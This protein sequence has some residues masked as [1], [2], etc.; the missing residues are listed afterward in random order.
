MIEVDF[1]MDMPDWEAFLQDRPA[2]QAVPAGAFLAVLEQETEDTVEEAFEVLNDL[3]LTLDMTSMPK[4]VVQGTLAER[5]QL[6]ERLVKTGLKP[7]AFQQTDPLRL[8]LEELAMIPA[9]GDETR[10][11]KQAAAGDEDAAMRLTNLGLSRVVEL[12]QEFVGRGVLLLDL[13]QEGSLALWQTVQ[14]GAFDNYAAFRDTCIRNAMSKLVLLQARSSGIGQKMRAALQDYRSVDEQ[15]LAELGR[16]PTAK[17]IAEKLHMTVEETEIVKKMLDD[18]VLL[19]QTENGMKP[20]E[21]PEEEDQA[22]EDTAYFQ[23]R[24]RIQELLSVLPEK[25]A[26]LLTLR[27]GLNQAAPLSPE[28]TGARLGLSAQEVIAREMAALSKLRK[29]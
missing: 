20:R 27:Y 8:Y 13:I 2:G 5:L 9:F 15:L 26:Q 14:S 18:A 1:T 25:D 29:N 24:Q 11:A 17:E 12:A 19:Q 21:E 4:P 23:M 6:E 28:D 22:V 10:L 3:R 7:E 16:N